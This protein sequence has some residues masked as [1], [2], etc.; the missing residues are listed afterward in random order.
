MF[1]TKKKLSILNILSISRFGKEKPDDGDGDSSDSDEEEGQAFYAGGSVNSGQEIL[2]PKKGKE[3]DFVK[4]IFKKA[5][6]H[7]AEAVDQNSA[8]GPAGAS[9]RP[10]FSGSGFKLGS[11]GK[12]ITDSKLLAHK[13]R[14]ILRDHL[15]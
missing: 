15:L 9:S 1:E 8:P 7:G 11:T 14:E 6:E 4:G 5:R 12:S 10:T 3:S 13:K 2:G